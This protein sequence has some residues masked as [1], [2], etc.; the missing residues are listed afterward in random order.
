MSTILS[1]EAEQTHAR[2]EHAVPT[3][4]MDLVTQEEQLFELARCSDDCICC[5]IHDTA[6][7]QFST[8]NSSKKLRS[9]SLQYQALYDL[10]EVYYTKLFLRGWK[11]SFVQE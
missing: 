6:T 2:N 3:K 4:F 10:T 11:N 5:D 7:F 8:E 1:S 9:G